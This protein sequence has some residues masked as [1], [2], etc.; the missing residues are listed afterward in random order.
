MVRARSLLARSAALATEKP[1][2]NAVVSP[3]FRVSS[4]ACRFSRVP[5][6][7]N[8]IGS[9]FWEVIS[10][11]HG[12]DATGQYKGED[13]VQLERIAV[14]YTEADKKRYV[15]RSVMVDLEPGTMDSLRASPY[16]G[17]FKPDNFVFG[18]SGAGNNWAKVS[19]KKRAKHSSCG[20]DA[21]SSFS[22]FFVLGSL[23]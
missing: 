2:R 22:L 11:E 13:D 23:H 3:S 14:Y 12:I 21:S 5:R 9:K 4:L 16:G 18:Q 20:I 19:E 7:G 6:S 1:R 10:A 17:V 8:Q 15:P